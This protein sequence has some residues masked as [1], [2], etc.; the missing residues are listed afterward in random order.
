MNFSYKFTVIIPVYNRGDMVHIAFESVKNQTM[1]FDDIEVLIVNDGSTDDSLKKCRALAGNSKN[2]K[3]LDKPNGGISSARNCGI[4]NATGKYIAFLD[5]DDAL[6]E[7]TLESAYNLFEEHYDEIDLLTYKITYIQNGQKAK[8]RHFRYDVLTETGVY[9]LEENPSIV[10]TTINVCIKNQA[11][12]TK[13]FD[14]SLSY[15]EDQAYNNAVLA[16]KMKIGFVEDGEYL[17]NRHDDSAVSVSSSAIHCFEKF[18]NYFETLFGKYDAVPKYYQCCFLHNLTYRLKD[19]V[20]FPYHYNEKDFAAAMGR[21]SS[22]LARVDETTMFIDFPMDDFYRTYFWCLKP[23]RKA[24]LKFND[25][26]QELVLGKRVLMERH[27]VTFVVKRFF[28]DGKSA[29]FIGYIRSPFFNFMDKPELYLNFYDG[30]RDIQ[31][32]LNKSSFCYYFCKHECAKAWSFDFTVNLNRTVNFDFYCKMGERCYPCVYE[33]NSNIVAKPNSPGFIYM[34]ND[35]RIQLKENLF[36]VKKMSHSEYLRRETKRML[37]LASTKPAD[38]ISYMIIKELKKNEIWLYNDNLYTVKDNAYYQFKHDFNKDDGVKRYYVMDGDPSRMKGLFTPEEEKHIVKFASKKHIL[39]FFAASKIITSFCEASAFTPV[40]PKHRRMFFD[41]TDFEVIYLQHGILH[42]TT[43]T[44]YSKDRVFVDKIVVSSQ[45]EIDN[46]T[47][48]Y[49]YN[50]SD[51]IPSGMPRYDY[52]DLAK[53]PKNRI[54]YAPS[55]RDK[56]VGKYVNRERKFYDSVLKNSNYY[57]GIVA[58]L[59]DPVLLEALEKNDIIL[60]FKPHPNFRGYAHLF[61]PFLN[62][63]IVLAAPNVELADY[64]LFITDFSSFNFDYI[65]QGRQLLYFVPDLDDFKCGA[66]TFYRDIDLKFEDGFGDYTTDPHE[67]AELVV[68]RINC[69]FET[70]EKYKNR[71]DNFFLS[72]GNHCEKLYRYLKK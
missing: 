56:L 1:N 50:F 45:F 33:F 2:V 34:K 7:K 70:D 55:W 8:W 30:G 69:N 23:N 66:V 71:I 42:A 46:L 14:E 62:D 27:N 57:K 31:I 12:N 17:Y 9:S 11:E 18:M 52:T 58:F 47:E 25:F 38:G 36:M 72:K 54:L 51:L 49:G 40:I 13:L 39:L 4:K 65:Y 68:K 24:E 19:D 22:L 61:E 28:F 48:N 59:T 63:R 3:V 53:K 44:K 21:I 16:D 15:M 20:L 60:D 6:E 43:P 37:H 26:S 41:L 29:R 5:D 32:E 67:A 10:Q 35:T 64:K